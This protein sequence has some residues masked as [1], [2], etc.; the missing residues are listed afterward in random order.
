[1]NI[2]FYNRYDNQESIEKVYG[3]REIVFLY[4][5]FAGKSLRHLLCGKLFSKFYGKLQNLP[6]SKNKI[7][8]FIRNF[9]IK[10]GDFLPEDGREMIDPY[11]TFN[12][13]FIR[14]FKEGKRNFPVDENQMGAFAEARYLGFKRVT[15]RMTV[16]VKGFDLSVEEILANKIW[17]RTFAGGPLLLAR[18]CPVDYH[19]FHFVDEGR[20]LAQ[21][22]IEG[23]LDSVN[24]L[25]LSKKTDIFFTNERQITIVESKNFGKLAY[26]DVGA[27]CVGK[28]IQT[29]NK[30]NHQRGEEKGY[31]LFGGSTV[32]VIGEERRWYPSEDILTKTK[33]GIE[34]YVRLGD[35]VAQ[36]IHN[37]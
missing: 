25:A 7:K 20:V 34:T 18:L 23:D 27:I 3:S 2:K 22:R 8:P 11:S 33:E 1:V 29:S 9:D 35:V 12:H 26:V 37:H 16:P 24:P 32:I 6:S 5:T 13:F 19:R 28:I 36:K 10:I 21:Y 14:R 17:N 31:F 15:G 4:E 30:E